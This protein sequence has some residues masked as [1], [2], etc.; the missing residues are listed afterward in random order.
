MLK[1]EN[2]NFFIAFQR[3][4]FH[5][6]NGCLQHCIEYLLPFCKLP[7]SAHVYWFI[8]TIHTIMSVTTDV[9][10]LRFNVILNVWFAISVHLTE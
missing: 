2:F 1:A 4:I 10:M 5:F 7:E 8:R 6:N 9:C 3:F